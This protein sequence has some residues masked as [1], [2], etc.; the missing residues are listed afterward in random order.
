MKEASAV[1]AGLF[2]LIMQGADPD[3]LDTFNGGKENIDR[4]N[5]S[6]DVC[7]Y[8]ALKKVALLKTKALL[9]KMKKGRRL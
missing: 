8:T 4:L 9:G 2:V 5:C 6:R 3:S 7:F 1:C